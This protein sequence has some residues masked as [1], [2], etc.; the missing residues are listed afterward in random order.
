MT[1]VYTF[2]TTNASGCDSTASLNLTINNTP[3]INIV[4]SST[5]ICYGDTSII[6][7]TIG[8]DSYEWYSINQSAI[9]SN[10]NSI[11]VTSNSYFVVVS[12]D[13]CIAISDTITISVITIPDP[14]NVT[15]SNIGLTSATMSWDA[16]SVT[17][18][19]DFRFREVGSSTWNTITNFLGTSYTLNG[20]SD[21]TDYI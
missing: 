7:A 5:S 1:G 9:I 6:N 3:N 10:N 17:G 13:G 2:T 16:V 8:L 15:A 14:T 18:K 12:D 21:G 4:A 19:Y 20:L 11:N